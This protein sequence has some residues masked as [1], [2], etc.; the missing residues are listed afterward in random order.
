MTQVR[1]HCRLGL[2]PCIYAWSIRVLGST[3]MSVL[4]ST[5]FDDSL[6]M[7]AAETWYP[8]DPQMGKYC[9]VC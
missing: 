8:L 4:G 5:N 7:L 6:C 2:P 9:D 1:I 3:N